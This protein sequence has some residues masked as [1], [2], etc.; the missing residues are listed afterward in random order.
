MQVDLQYFTVPDVDVTLK[1]I[2]RQISEGGH[3][4][5]ETVVRRRGFRAVWGTP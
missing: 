5:P 3:D 2:A 1:R 4:V